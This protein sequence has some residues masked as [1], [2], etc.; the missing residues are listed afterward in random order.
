MR[1]FTVW[2][3]TVCCCIRLMASSSEFHQFGLQ[4][5]TQMDGLANNTLFTVHQDKKGF[6]WLGT[7]VGVSRYDGVH[8]HN[9]EL[10]SIEP[11]AVQRICEMERDSLLWLELGRY[12]HI[13]C[14]DKTNGLYIPL[15][16]TVKGLLD[17]IYD[18]C[19]ADSVLYAITSKGIERLDYQREESSIRITPETIA[20]H[21]YPLK[22]LKCDKN[23]LFA[24]DQGNN[25]LIYNYRNKERRVLSY[26][27]L[28]TEK[29]VENIH[30]MNGCLWI[31]TSWN[32]TYC[33]V[34]D[35]D[36]LRCL[37]TE[38]DKLKDISIS[39]MAMKDDST[40]I[41]STPHAI[42]RI[43]FSG[44]DYLHDDV[45]VAEIPFDNFMYDSFVK[46][47]IT[48]LFVDNQNDAIWMTTF[49][50]GLL[51]SNMMDK[52]VHRI[53]LDNNIND[54]NG[55]AEDANG[56]IWL[57]T[58]HHGIW[59]STKSGLTRDTK[60][61]LWRQSSPQGYYCMYKDEHGNLW[62]A[63][64]LGT[65]QLMNPLSDRI[66][67]F[68]PTYD[69]VNSIGAIRKIYFCIHNHLWLVSDKGL[70]IYDH[71]KNEC[72]ASMP[73]N[74]TI[75][76][77]TSLCEERDGMMWLGTNDGIRVA[78][79]NEKEIVM[80]NGREQKAG[81]SKSEVLNIYMNRYNELYIS[82]ADKIV[83]TDG[84]HEDIVD[85]KI[86]QK[87][88][89][90]GHIQ[91]IIDDKNGNT[92]MGNNMGVMI[93]NNKTKAS[94]TYP[95]PERFYNVCQL[96]DGRLL[97]SNS[98]GLM[99][100]NPREL[101]RKS[102]TAPL[103]ISDIGINYNKV[104]IGEEIN[105][106][107][108][109]KKPAYLLDKLTLNHANNNIIF[110]L[111]NLRYNQMPNKIEYRLLPAE[112][113]WQR[114]YKA[115]IEYSDLSPG[116]YTLEIR[117]V[118]IN[119]EEVV[120]TKL[121]IEVKKHW[122][123]T[124]W[125]FVCYLLFAALFA[126]LAFY[127]LRAKAVRRLFYRKKEDLL[128][129]TLAEEIKGRKEEKTI[130]RLRNQ[131]RYSLA[132]ELRTPL[133]LVSAPLKEL[134]GASILPQ[135]LLPKVKVAYRNTISMQDVCNLMLDIYEKE[136]EEMNLSVA[137]YSVSNI[138]N[139]A[140]ITSNELLNVAPIKL[141]YDKDTNI[142]KEL[143][144]D[145]KKIEYILRNILSNA[146]R[147][148]NYS[149]NVKVTASLETIDG[150]EY[151]CYRIEDDG[152]SIIEKSAVYLLSKEEGGNEL[153]SQLHAEIGLI[154]MKEYI[155]A[156]HGDIRIEQNME[157]GSCVS[158][159]I[160]L[161]K[162]HFEEDANVVFVEPETIK[163][164][165][166]KPHAIITA[167]E[168]EEQIRKEQESMSLLSSSTNGKYKM[169]VIEDHKDIRLYL[170][171]LFGSEYA[172]VMAE[173]GEEGVKMARRELPDIILTDI[174]MPVMDGFEATRQLKEDLKTCHIPIVMLTALAGDTNAVKGLDSGADD[175]ILKPFNAEILRSKVKR[176]IE[177]RQNLKQAYMRLMMTTN[178][179]DASG[180]QEDGEQKED[181]FIRQIFEIV[182]NNL[183]NP[184]FNVKR[185]AEMVNMSQPTLYRRVKMLTNYT[186]I[187]LI[188]GVRLR[189]AA[190][191]LRT[192]KYS[193]QEVSEMVGYNDAPTFRKHFVDFYG[194]TPSNYANQKEDTKNSIS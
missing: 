145:R 92:W 146:Y 120:T 186:I 56:Y 189:N 126:T 7:D 143:W 161:G 96:N 182:E 103:Y 18:I 42:L 170:K 175:Y 15:E 168:K 11:Q 119:D 123:S 106:Q 102:L 74:D 183:Q 137:S 149:G 24:L 1:F 53:Y 25:V 76:R 105:G 73:Y 48:S 44:T 20:E 39:D 4:H 185:L 14:L 70:F 95:F 78:S 147:H 107:V 191:L 61:E 160:P 72:V 148:I 93:V 10:I 40:L 27:R 5:L 68:K 38:S 26:S 54:V 49:G 133:S 178:V 124:G 162:E 80:S 87:D 17:E 85:I 144:V 187:E 157:T 171:V 88:M 104:D 37:S 179:K 181:P 173:N 167:E 150:K 83:Q 122:A 194:T 101:K 31:T 36:E 55:V 192:K 6:F 99:Y 69:G 117:P 62:I 82:Y 63:D 57:T 35:K 97:W 151:C 163:S 8:F 109:L 98:T 132:R 142:K 30:V 32:G 64:D 34:P 90:S 16:S 158:V 116:E 12:H 9:Y 13:A 164:E 59:R 112:T 193:I 128:R 51:K 121:D 111:T 172:V 108:V 79:V 165:Q 188:R 129:N 190:E 174:M 155:A 41:A 67:N 152:K 21:K 3:L 166:E 28:Q 114:N 60:F 153:T 46:D 86:L 134:I 66:E 71:L 118:S 22:Q 113:E 140:I 84:Q 58:D 127:Y 110:Y 135:A 125:A 156:H 47:R 52:D 136:N 29:S 77:I 50:K 180:E 131:A 138:L 141:H 91:C 33:Y 159:Y 130:Q 100:F 45:D 139:N 184:D 19:I 94:Y 89:V 43:A 23:H 154:L 177:N 65:V 169:L 176:L 75:S 81:V 2:L 115:E